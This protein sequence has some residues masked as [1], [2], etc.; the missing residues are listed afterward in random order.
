M[1]PGRA[2]RLLGENRSW[3][4]WPARAASCR[5]Q[6]WWVS[7]L[8]RQRKLLAH[9]SHWRDCAFRAGG[10]SWGRG[11][12]LASGSEGVCG[13]GASHSGHPQEPALSL[14]SCRPCPHSRPGGSC[15][16]HLR[17]GGRPRVLPLPG[18]LPPSVGSCRRV[19]PGPDSKRMELPCPSQSSAC[20]GLGRACSSAKPEH[21]PG[22]SAELS[23]MYSV[24]CLTTTS[25]TAKRKESHKRDHCLG[26]L[27]A[28]RTS[29]S[30]RR[31]QIRVPQDQGNWDN[32]KEETEWLARPEKLNLY[33]GRDVLTRI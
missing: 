8:T 9:A 23:C 10:L 14:L 27:R 15:L 30:F 18:S 28:K 11:R 25:S 33:S 17:F 20:S 26:C 3:A 32:L 12:G 2:T 1:W 24:S 21:S 29:A 4:G 22:R 6:R 5:W 7:R 16:W 31:A 13:C 19:S